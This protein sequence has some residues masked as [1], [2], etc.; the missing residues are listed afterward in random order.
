METDYVTPIESN[1]V[2]TAT[3]NRRSRIILIV[4]IALLLLCCCCTL[5]VIIGWAGWTY[6]DTFLEQLSSSIINNIV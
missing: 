2:E 6:G 5:A 4:G 1:Q 3:T